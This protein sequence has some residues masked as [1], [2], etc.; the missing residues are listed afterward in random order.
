MKNIDISSAQTISYQLFK[1][2]GK[3]IPI[4][5]VFDELVLLYLYNTFKDEALSNNIKELLKLENNA[6]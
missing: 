6:N 2:F 3:R 4:S 5:A 1:K